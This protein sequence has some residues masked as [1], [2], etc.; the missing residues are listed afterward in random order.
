MANEPQ[1]VVIGHVAENPMM[2]TACEWLDVFVDQQGQIRKGVRKNGYWELE[3]AEAGVYEFE[4]RRW[5]REA[6]TGLG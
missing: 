5:P 1:R 3:V 6:D 4:L 2:L